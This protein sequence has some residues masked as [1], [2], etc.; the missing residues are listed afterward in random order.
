MKQ[1]YIKMR[2]SSK[3]D[4]NWFYKYYLNSGGKRIDLKTFSSL[5]QFGDLSSVLDFLDAK[6]ELTKLH[7]ADGKFLKIVE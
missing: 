2:N 5:F 1:E 4:V 7:D 3:Y 6:F